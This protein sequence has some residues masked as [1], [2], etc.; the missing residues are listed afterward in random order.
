MRWNRRWEQLVSSYRCTLHSLAVGTFWELG[1]EVRMMGGGWQRNQARMMG[2]GWVVKPG[3]VVCPSS[4]A[5]GSEV[6]WNAA[7]A[8]VRT[9]AS[10]VR[11][12]R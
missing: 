7:G 10:K 9:L 8:C 4:V 12:E 2:G 11:R 5:S 6:K 3:G 1:V